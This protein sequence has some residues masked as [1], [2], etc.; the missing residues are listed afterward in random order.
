MAT[1]SNPV[2]SNDA[3]AVVENLKRLVDSCRLINPSDLCIL[4]NRAVFVLMCDLICLDDDGNVMDACILA[5]VEALKDLRLPKMLVLE[6]SIV[7]QGPGT[8]GLSLRI[9]PIPLS[10]AI[11]E[12]TLLADPTFEEE[13]VVD[14]VLT[15]WVDLQSNE[16]SVWKPGGP[17]ISLE[18]VK[19]VLETC[20]NRRVEY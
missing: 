10:F 6:D 18:K 15:A 13:A 20:K 3:C 17:T 8:T 4:P 11:F 7:R 9:S 2:L 12:G 16:C 19:I 5:L 1:G 14:G